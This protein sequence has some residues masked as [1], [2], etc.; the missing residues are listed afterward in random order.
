MVLF[1][2]VKRLFTCPTAL[3]VASCCALRAHKCSPLGDMVGWDRAGGTMHLNTFAD[4][5]VRQVTVRG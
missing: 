5:S 3:F 1:I 2:S 4:V